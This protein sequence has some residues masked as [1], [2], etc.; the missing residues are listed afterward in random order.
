MATKQKQKGNDSP[1]PDKFEVTI[2]IKDPTEARPLV[3]ERGLDLVR[4]VILDGGDRHLLVLYLNKAEIAELKKSGYALEVGENVS[5]QGLKRQT[6]VAKG[7][8][9]DG[10]RIPPKGL[11]VQRAPAQ[12]G[13]GQEGPQ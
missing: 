2:E 13:S 11:G 9:F 3:R 6:E 8:R 7:D 5:E 12:D 4:S 1:P 10:G